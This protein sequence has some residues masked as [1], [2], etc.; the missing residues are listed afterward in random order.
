MPQELLQIG[1]SFS[2]HEKVNHFSSNQ[3]P[4][5]TSSFQAVTCRKLGPTVLWATS[6]NLKETENI[7]ISNYFKFFCMNS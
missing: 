6:L 7:L 3:I 4:M 1:Y 2:A 5:S